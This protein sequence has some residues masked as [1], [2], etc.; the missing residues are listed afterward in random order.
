MGI[1]QG[2]C[3]GG[4]SLGILG[5]CPTIGMSR[6]GMSLGGVSRGIFEVCPGCVPWVCP[7]GVSLP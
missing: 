6:G 2:A 1:S 5:A 3:P 4:V 7:G